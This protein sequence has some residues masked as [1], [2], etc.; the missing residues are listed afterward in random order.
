LQLTQTIPLN[1]PAGSPTGSYNVIGELV[2]AKV[3]AIIWIDVS[4]NFPSSQAIGVVNYSSNSTGEAAGEVR[5][6]YNHYNYSDYHHDANN[7]HY[8]H[9]D[10]EYDTDSTPTPASVPIIISPGVVNVSPVVNS[11]GIFTQS[12]TLT[13]S[14]GLVSLSIPSVQWADSKWD[15]VRTNQH[16]AGYIATCTTLRGDFIGPAYNFEPSGATFSP[17]I[18]MKFTYN[19]RT[20]RVGY[21]RTVW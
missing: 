19:R 14:D 3:H 17:A 8:D 2:S 11:Q 10:N 21:L 15:S 6:N 20:Y 7:D 9:H 13:S 4:D 16:L 5:W 1:F 12:V 18:Y